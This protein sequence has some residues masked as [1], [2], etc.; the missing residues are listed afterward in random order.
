M[1]EN[2]G[3][4]TPYDLKRY[5]EMGLF[6]FWTVPHTKVYRECA[7]LADAGYLSERRERKGRRRRIYELTESGRQALDEWRQD[8]HTEVFEFRDEGLLK[9]YFGADRRALASQQVE[10]HTQRLEFLKAV[11]E[12]APMTGGMRGVLEAALAL[13]RDFIAFWTRMRDE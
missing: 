6:L 8:P 13:Q 3:P 12:N 4:A 7:R 2:L 10:T 1:F 11:H 5:G 9:L